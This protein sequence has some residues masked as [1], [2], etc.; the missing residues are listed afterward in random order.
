MI[1]VMLMMLLVL[2]TM[3]IVGLVQPAITG[4]LQRF[5][6]ADTKQQ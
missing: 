1:T 4:L 5:C 2:T 6:D 3:A